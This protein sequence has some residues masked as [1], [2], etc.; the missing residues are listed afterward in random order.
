MTSHV[1]NINR[2]FIPCPLSI[3]IGITLYPTSHGDGGH[4]VIIKWTL[5][6]CLCG[7]IWRHIGLSTEIWYDYYL[8]DNLVPFINWKVIGH[9]G[10]HQNKMSL[11]CLVDF[12]CIVVPMGVR[13]SKLHSAAIVPN[14]CFVIF[15]SLIVKNMSVAWVKFV[16]FHH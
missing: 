15:W 9:N 11:E 13:Q 8:R 14:C 7:N 1:L 16:A 10:K 4:S 5:V 6:M 12:L 3:W 2:V